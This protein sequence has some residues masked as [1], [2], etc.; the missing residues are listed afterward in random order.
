MEF[1]FW[2]CWSCGQGFAVGIGPTKWAAFW[3]CLREMVY[4][5]RV[6]RRRGTSWR[7]IWRGLT[8]YGVDCVS[9]SGVETKGGADERPGP[10]CASG[11]G[12][13]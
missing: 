8:I 5:V 6:W 4:L 7:T 13:H 1:W 12:S 2:D 3:D 11:R 9:L 10:E